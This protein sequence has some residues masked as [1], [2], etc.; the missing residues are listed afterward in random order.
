MRTSS[1]RHR[2]AVATTIGAAALIATVGMGGVASAAAISVP[3][4]RTDTVFTGLAAGNNGATEAEAA[5]GGTTGVSGAVATGEPASAT[6]VGAAPTA[7]GG[8]AEADG[9][10]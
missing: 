4:G 8:P 10:V 1:L 7:F 9:C 6:G 3:S 2:L 5:A